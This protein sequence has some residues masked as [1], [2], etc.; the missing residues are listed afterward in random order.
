MKHRLVDRILAWQPK[1]SIRGIKTVSLEEYS[2]KEAFGG[3]PRLPESLVLE[4]IVQLGRWLLVLSSDFAR[5]GVLAGADRVC[6]EAFVQPGEHMVIDV[7]VREYNQ[8]CMAFDATGRT[9]R[10][11]C[12]AATGCILAP[13]PLC[14][15]CDPADLRTLYGEIYQPRGDQ[16]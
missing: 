15:C 2:L 14:T 1:T 16:P 13:L 8:D 11:A 9:S 10:R 4:S 5:T 12:V 6:F 7:T 3:P